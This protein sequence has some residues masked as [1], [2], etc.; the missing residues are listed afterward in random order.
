M[1]FV[2]YE[3]YSFVW[4]ECNIY[5]KLFILIHLGKEYNYAQYIS[6]KYNKYIANILFINF[7]N[8]FYIEKN[9][10]NRVN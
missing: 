3:E 4:I 6:L 9:I 2:S 1:I 7:I 8:L 5:I 10:F